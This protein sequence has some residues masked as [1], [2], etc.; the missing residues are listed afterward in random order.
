MPRT[1]VIVAVDDD[2]RPLEALG[3]LLESAGYSVRPFGSAKSF[4][5]DGAALSEAD[6]LISDIGMPVTDGFELGDMVKQA[7]PGLPIILVTARHETADERRAIAQGSRFFRKPV[8]SQ[9]LLAAICEALQNEDGD[10]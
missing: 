7:R 10:E 3:D 8:D 9:V 1:F 5:D 2:P 6:C 4:L